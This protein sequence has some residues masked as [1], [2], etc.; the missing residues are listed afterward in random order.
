MRK[1]AAGHVEMQKKEK[2]IAISPESSSF[3]IGYFN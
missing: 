3:L 2:K 1:P